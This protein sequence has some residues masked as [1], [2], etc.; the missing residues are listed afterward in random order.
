MPSIKT[1]YLSNKFDVLETKK[2]YWYMKI[3]IIIS[4]ALVMNKEEM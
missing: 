1:S 2:Q 3:Q 4:V